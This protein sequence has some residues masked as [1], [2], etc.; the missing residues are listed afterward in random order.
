MGT[1]S[2]T[3]H[4]NS[5]TGFGTLPADAYPHSLVE[6]GETLAKKRSGPS[7]AEKQA[8]AKKKAKKKKAKKAGKPVPKKDAKNGKKQQVVKPN[9]ENDKKLVYPGTDAVGSMIPI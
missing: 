7:K 1:D 6:I 9:S 2:K 5:K 3:A 8:K 4:W